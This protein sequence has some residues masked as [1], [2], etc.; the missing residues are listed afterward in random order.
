MSKGFFIEVE[1]INGVGKSTLVKALGDALTNAKYNV[2]LCREPGGTQFGEASRFLFEQF[3]NDMDRIT[4]LFQ[5]SASRR[6]LCQ[7]VIAPALAAG[8]VVISDRFASSTLAH[9]L[10]ANAQDGDWMVPETNCTGY[11]RRALVAPSL[12]LT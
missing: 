2:V 12:N 4:K 3:H 10:G 7:K 8:K 11:H 9:Q 5:F 6:V 1:G